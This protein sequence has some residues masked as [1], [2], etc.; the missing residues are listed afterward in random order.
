MDR[1]NG[2]ALADTDPDRAENVA[3]S[4]TDPGWQ[5]WALTNIGMI[6]VKTPVGAHRPW[7]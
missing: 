6:R 3:R 4:I 5:A 7:R 2:P 1:V